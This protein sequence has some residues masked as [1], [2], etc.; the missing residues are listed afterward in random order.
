M[1]GNVNSEDA[2]DSDD[3]GE[4]EGF[5]GDPTSDAGF[6]P[7]QLDGEADLRR[8]VFAILDMFARKVTALHFYVLFHLY[9]PLSPA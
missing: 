9:I 5:F 1:Y 6:P 8:D 2:A 4:D 3:V 7:M